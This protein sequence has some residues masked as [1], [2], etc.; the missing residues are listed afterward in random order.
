MAS[1][2]AGRLAGLAT[3]AGLAYMATRD[4]D[5]DKGK[6][7][8]KSEIK[9]PLVVPKKMWQQ[10]TRQRVLLRTLC[11]SRNP[12]HTRQTTRLCLSRSQS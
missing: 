12:G 4:K 10:K 8:A 9:E 5:K 3:L 1:K 11:L 6:G 2:K 7:A